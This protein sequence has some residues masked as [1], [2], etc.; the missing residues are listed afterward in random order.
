MKKL[1]TYWDYLTQDGQTYQM[2]AQSHRVYLLDLLAEK[3]VQ[4]ILDVGCGTGP[5]YQL[6]TQGPANPGWNFKYKGTD[7][8]DGM[9]EVCKKEFPKG[10]FEVQD[11]RH[12]L[13]VSDSWECVLLMHCL[14]HLDD[15]EAAIQEAA[16]V[17]SKYV[18]IV[19]WRGINYGEG[20]VNNLNNRSRYGK[21]E[22]EP[23]WE[24]THLQD[25]AWAPLKVAFD[26]SG[27]TVV[28]KEE[29]EEVNKE[30]KY[31]TVLLLEKDDGASDP[32]PRQGDTY[33]DSET[34][35]KHVFTN[36]KWEEMQ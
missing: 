30:G 27:L 7:Y 28:L 17:S 15:Y 4:S 35:K 25:Y 21:E 10:D 22:G 26:K 33:T 34:G 23:D 29:G 6:I 31:N 2:G 11:A 9:I 36:G 13:E 5:I 32:N 20:A 3:K 14:D 18:L 24:D 8:S 1:R 12:L 19:L 16:R